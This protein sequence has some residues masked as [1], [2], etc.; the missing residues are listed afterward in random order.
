MKLDR[1]L[2]WSII[3]AT[4]LILGIILSLIF[5]NSTLGKDDFLGYSFV[6][7]I[8]RFYG[9]LSLVFFIAVLSVGIPGAIIL[10]QTDKILKAILFSILFWFISV[11]LYTVAFNF[12]NDTLHLGF[13]SLYIILAGLTVG[14]NLKIRPIPDVID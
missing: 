9:G 3:I 2:I 6:N 12:F 1:T 4:Q 5:I 8:M 7:G 13:I 10:R 14:F 11:I